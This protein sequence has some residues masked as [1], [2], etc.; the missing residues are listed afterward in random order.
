MIDVIS[1]GSVQRGFVFIPQRRQI[2]ET[3]L[4]LNYMNVTEYIRMCIYFPGTSRSR[5]DCFIYSLFFIFFSKIINNLMQLIIYTKMTKEKVITYQQHKCVQFLQKRLKSVFSQLLVW[6]KNISCNSKK[7]II[8]FSSPCK[9]NDTLQLMKKIPASV[10]IYNLINTNFL[11]CLHS[12]LFSFRIL[13]SI[14]SPLDYLPF[15]L[16]LITFLGF[17]FFSTIIFLYRIYLCISLLN[18]QSDP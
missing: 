3:H 8:I 13:F 7:E 17:V 14:S 18:I 9:F 16:F 15:L 1:T 4:C 11:L 12:T 2:W 5:L 10:F 6:Y